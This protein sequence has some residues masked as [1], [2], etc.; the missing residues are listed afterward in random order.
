M[1]FVWYWFLVSPATGKRYKNTSG[2]TPSGV[3]VGA[4]IQ[5]GLP[6]LHAARAVSS[7]PVRNNAKQLFKCCTDVAGDML[8][9]LECC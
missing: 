4:L 2:L 1:E 5:W 3:E 8:L 9:L 7:A 6:G